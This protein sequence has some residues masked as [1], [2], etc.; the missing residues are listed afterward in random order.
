MTESSKDAGSSHRGETSTDEAFQAARAQFAARRDYKRALRRARNPLY[1]SARSLTML[2]LLVILAG[3]ATLAIVFTL[4]GDPTRTGARPIIHVL[5]S[6]SDSVPAVPPEATAGPAVEVILA[7]ETPA[8]LILEGPAIP[9]VII[10]NTPIPLSVGLQAEVYGVGNDKLNI[11]NRPSLTDSQVLFREDEGKRFDVIG[12]PQEADGYTWWQVR[13]PQFQVEGW[14]VA[15]YLRTI[16][17]SAG[18]VK[19]SQ[20]IKQRIIKLS[21]ELHHH[22][23]LYHVQN[24]PEITDAEYDRLFR[25]LQ[26]LEAAHPEFAKPDSPTQ[27]VGSD[28]SGDFP[29]VRHSAPIL[30][31]SNAFD[32]ADLV[33]WEERNRRL[34]PAGAAMQYVLQPKLDGLAIVIS[35]ENGAMTRAATRG[36]GEYGDDVTANVKTIRTVPLRIPVNPAGGAAPGRLVVRGEILF[37]KDAFVELNREQ[38]A[39]GLPAYVNA[40]NTASGSLKQKDSR[41]TAKRK[42]TAYI[43]DIVDSE[44]VELESES[45]TLQYLGDMGFNVIADAALCKDLADAI[46]RLPAWE[47]RRDDLPFEI[48][49]MV[50]KVDSRAQASELGVVGKDPRGAI[51]Y[52]FAAEEA[53]TRLV[54]LTIGVGRT[55]KVTPT[56]QLEPV[57]IGGVT[58]SNASLHNYEQVAALDIR[59]GDRVIVKRSGDVIPYVIGPVASA[60]DGSETAIR[61]P[62]HCPF[63]ATKLIQPAEAVDWFCPNLRCPERVARTLEFF[64]SRGAMDIEGMGPQ[65]IIALIENGLI[66]DEADIF[67]LDAEPLLALDGFAEKKVE[68]LLAS[69]EEAKTRS[70]EQVLTS[71]GIDGVGSTVAGLLTGSFSSMQDLRDTASKIRA[72]EERFVQYSEPLLAGESSEDA[73]IGKLLFRLRHPLTELAPRYLDADLGERLSRL[74]KPL[75]FTA[76]QRKGVE[77]PLLQLIAASR[78][79]H[80]IEGLGPVLVENIVAWFTDDHNQS[81]LAKMQAAGVNMRAAEKAVAGSGLAG[82][83]FV[84]TGA[85]SMPRGE[86]KALV[87][88]N[89]GKVSSSVS[90][91]TSYVVAG[92]SPGS[93]VE[94]A[95]KSKVPVI[96]EEDLRALIAG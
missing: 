80:R 83:T 41:E 93:K 21:G 6:P 87:E 84:L 24:A 30:S 32:D 86:I 63:C 23:Y 70:F 17:E 73:A 66:E 1:F 94:K 16:S 33:N 2:V 74:L 85:M 11:R 90:K 31:L 68:N 25:Q 79:L 77:E 28:L 53:S 49:G 40:R 15:N 13:D 39:Q 18:T 44:G 9:T 45:N 59:Q 35:Y 75:Q 12:G 96:S 37:H 92:D 29:K 88:A 34:L 47:A 60:R 4:R 19:M 50:L 36:N 26:D 89:G 54:G 82:K 22:I 62:E 65:T 91:R 42:L 55:G 56:A 78:P 69:I 51:A 95:E 20:D 58:V 48:D 38:Q 3:A 10:T 76:E 81:V 57:F 52:K 5:R 14:A 61:P 27:R 67:T 7:V 64:V 8:N 71:L 43:Y 46:A 72:A